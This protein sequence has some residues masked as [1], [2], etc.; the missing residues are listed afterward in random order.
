[1]D[2]KNNINKLFTVLVVGG[3]IMAQANANEV[4]ENT[5]TE[6]QE[7]CQI[8]LTLN[9]YRMG[10]EPKKETVCVDK[11]SDGEVLDKLDK[12]RD[13]TCLTPFCGCWL[14]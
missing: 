3:T 4:R 10:A 13:Q 8:E 7:L 9:K 14:G 11:K 5:P 12:F 1:M 2:M 6:P